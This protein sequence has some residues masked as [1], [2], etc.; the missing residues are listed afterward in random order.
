MGWGM[1]RASS[2]SF[3]TL[4]LR[5]HNNGRMYKMSRRGSLCMRCVRIARC[6]SHINLTISLTSVAVP[7]MKKQYRILAGRD[8]MDRCEISE[9]IMSVPQGLEHV[10]LSCVHW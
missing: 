5:C 9:L 10:S 2:V 4:A 7:G 8:V 1:P 6:C 3:R